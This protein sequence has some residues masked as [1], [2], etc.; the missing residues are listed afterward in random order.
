MSEKSLW[1][2]AK[3]AMFAASAATGE[4]TGEAAAKACDKTKEIAETAGEMADKA[5]DAGA[6]AWDKT[7]E[8]AAAAKDSTSKSS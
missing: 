6:K 3:E 2:K 1:D 7:K 5:G 8:A 4:K